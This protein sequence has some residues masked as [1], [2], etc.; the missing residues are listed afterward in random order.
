MGRPFKI[1]SGQSGYPPLYIGHQWGEPPFGEDSMVV[2]RI[3]EELEITAAMPE[4]LSDNDAFDF[5][6][7]Y[8]T[9]RKKSPLGKKRMGKDS[10]HISFA[11]AASDDELIGFVRMFGPV[12]CKTCKVQSNH[13][14]PDRLKAANSRFQML[15]IARQDLR[16]LRNEQRVYRA[17]LGLVAELGKRDSD[18]S[19]ET[20]RQQITEITEGIRDWPRQWNRERKLKRHPLWRLRQDSLR[21]IAALSR[22]NPDRILA[23][24]VDARIVM[25]ELINVFPAIA[26]P[27]P[28]EMHFYLRHGIRPL[29]YGVLRQEFFQPR[30]FGVCAN[31]QCRAFFEIERSGQRFCN[32]LCSRRQRQREYWQNRGK[33]T[34][35]ERLADSAET[36]NR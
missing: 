32:D 28:L 27:N 16:E 5:I 9:A 14:Q 7:Q 26:F 35:R 21:K 17:A 6:R 23:P 34:R 31:S 18:F 29:L 20:A 2:T 30:D 15:M 33:T 24:Q 19:F 4:Y 22:S 3:G 10:P 1:S 25:C 36:R 12:V 8:Q 13:G 11:N